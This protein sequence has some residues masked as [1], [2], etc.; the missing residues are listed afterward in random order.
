MTGGRYTGLECVCA[1]L[2]AENCANLH[3]G[4]EEG[5]EKG[6]GRSE[7]VREAALRGPRHLAR[8]RKLCRDDEVG[9]HGSQQ[10]LGTAPRELRKLVPPPHT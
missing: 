2:K 6:P 5:S 8:S 9:C 7:L 10:R 3:R 4:S 1:H